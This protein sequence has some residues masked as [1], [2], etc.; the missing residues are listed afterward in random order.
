MSTSTLIRDARHQAGL[1]QRAL[2]SAA[3]TSQPAVAR[4]ETGRATPRTDTLDRLLAA[5]GQ[6][7][8]TTATRT[9]L[10]RV[11]AG[12]KGRIVRRHRDAILAAVTAR[13]LR[14]PR[15]FGSVARGDDTGDSDIDVLVDFGPV[16][17]LLSLIGLKNDLEPLLGTPVDV[18]TP[19]I[20]KP[21]VRVNAQREAVPL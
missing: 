4:Y 21:A 16:P 10:E 11:P 5:C 20:L 9:R 3:G 2:A 8:V 14:N 1:S 17:D 18:A 7:L 6:G 13:G 19:D 12:P 15:I